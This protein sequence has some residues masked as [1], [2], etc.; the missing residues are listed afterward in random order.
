MQFSNPCSGLLERPSNALGAYRGTGTRI[1]FA[2]AFDSISVFERCRS[3]L[4]ALE[5]TV[6]YARRAQQRRHSRHAVS[7]SFG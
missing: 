3:R 1:A 4:R 7:T 2:V 6:S 5:I